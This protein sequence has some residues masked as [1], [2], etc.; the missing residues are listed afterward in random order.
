MLTDYIR[1]AMGHAEYEE[2]ADGSWYGHVAALAGVWA[3]AIER[4]ACPADLQSALEDWILF[5]LTNGFPI[6]AVDGIDLNA[7]KVA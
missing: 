7:A 5:R 3:D 1:A 6:P 4:D 2:L